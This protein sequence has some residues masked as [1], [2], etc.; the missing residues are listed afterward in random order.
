M[1]PTLASGRLQS[2]VCMHVHLYGRETALLSLTDCILFCLV[3]DNLA[4]II[5]SKLYMWLL[6]RPLASAA[7]SATVCARQ[8]AADGIIISPVMHVNNAR[9]DSISSII[10]MAS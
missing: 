8:A 7:A 10:I 3:E 4:I 2:C 1:S 5:M 6:V 9:V